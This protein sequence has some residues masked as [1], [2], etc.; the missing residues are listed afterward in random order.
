MRT[1]HH[2]A[3]LLFNMSC[4]YGY[5]TCTTG[6]LQ[7][8]SVC[9]KCADDGGH[10]PTVPGTFA[11]GHAPTVTGTFA[12]APCPINSVPY[13]AGDGLWMPPTPKVLPPLTRAT[14]CP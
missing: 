13:R 8:G 9:G 6:S 10:A 11:G 7:G 1:I 5:P 14:S 3:P 4:P 12:G 2:L